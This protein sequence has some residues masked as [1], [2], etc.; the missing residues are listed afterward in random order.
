MKS[1]YRRSERQAISP[2]PGCLGGFAPWRAGRFL[3][4]L[5]GPLLKAPR[6]V[7]NP[8]QA[9][10]LPHIS[11]ANPLP[12]PFAILLPSGNRRQIYAT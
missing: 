5:G 11:G 7:A 1:A 2:V 4:G 10:S 3:R 6:R 12:P 8:P 9:A